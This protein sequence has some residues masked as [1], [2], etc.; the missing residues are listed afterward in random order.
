MIIII[1]FAKHNHP[2]KMDHYIKEWGA[3]IPSNIEQALLTEK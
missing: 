3:H 1:I 2:L